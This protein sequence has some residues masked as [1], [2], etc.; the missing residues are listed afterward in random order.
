VKELIYMREVL[1][2]IPITIRLED[3]MGALKF[4]KKNSSIERTVV[5]FLEKAERVFPYV[6]TAGCE[7][8][9]IVPPKEDYM[10]VFKSCML[11]PR[12]S[13]SKRRAEYNPEM[14]KKF[15]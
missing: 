2:N 10:G 12:H 5:D 4:G 1:E 14:V 3:V 7:L 8:E 15:K 9:S 11:C 6:V 13:C